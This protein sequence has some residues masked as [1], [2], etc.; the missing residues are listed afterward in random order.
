MGVRGEAQRKSRTLSQDFSFSP[1]VFSGEDW[2]GTEESC[3]TLELCHM[4]FKTT[5]Q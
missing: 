5:G 1:C 3:F 4:S 2:A